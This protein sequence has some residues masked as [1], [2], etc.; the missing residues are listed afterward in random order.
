[1]NANRPIIANPNI[2]R[3]TLRYHSDYRM[4]RRMETPWSKLIDA[5]GGTSAVSRMIKTPTSTVHSWRAAGIPDARLD[6]LRLAAREHR[7]DVD[8]DQLIEEPA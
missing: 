8:V 2:G 3:K 5:L 1:M 6:H 4:F 7:P